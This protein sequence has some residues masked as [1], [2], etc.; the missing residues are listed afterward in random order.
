MSANA[1][2]FEKMPRRGLA[3]GVSTAAIVAAFETR[4]IR[5]GSREENLR[6]E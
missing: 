2:S 4:S 5:R 6:A 3:A 1:S